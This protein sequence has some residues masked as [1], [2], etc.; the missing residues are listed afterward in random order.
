MARVIRKPG[1]GLAQLKVALPGLEG[2]Q[3][4]VGWFETAKY[5]TGMPVAYAACI[6]ELGYPA[7]GIPARPFF[8]PTIKREEGNWRQIA[9]DGSKQIIK[10]KASIKQVME[11]IG[12][13][14]AGQVA[15]T[16]SQIQSPPLKQSTIDARRR[17]YAD[18]KTVGSLTKP[19][20]DSAIMV[21]T[22]T[23]KV[24]TK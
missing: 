12:M 19:L 8:R 23:H 10:G 16:I 1:P 15:K 9:F 13:Q 6:N 4:Q 22:V 14:A 20:V 3:G 18:R 17:K 21:N 24:V 7:G 2:A 5:P 11:A